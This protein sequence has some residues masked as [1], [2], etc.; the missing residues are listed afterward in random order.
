MRTPA[1]PQRAFKDLMNGLPPRLDPPSASGVHQPATGDHHVRK[2]PSTPA[3]PKRPHRSRR[4]WKSRMKTG[5]HL[6][7][8]SVAPRP[9]NTSCRSARR[10]AGRR[11]ARP[12]RALHRAATSRGAAEAG[13]GIRPEHGTRAPRPRHG[14]RG[15]QMQDRQRH[16]QRAASR[17]VEGGA[18][19]GQGRGSPHSMAEDVPGRCGGESGSRWLRRQAVSPAPSHGG[20]SELPGR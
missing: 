14:G 20:S 6:A 11:G 10:A 18:Q 2:A 1:P 7:C 3:R 17:Q 4:C 9:S 15:H 12:P 5:R 16:W 19:R 8:A 13:C